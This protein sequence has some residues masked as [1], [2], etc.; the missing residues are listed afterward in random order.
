MTC[1]YPEGFRWLTSHPKPRVVKLKGDKF[2]RGSKSI[3]NRYRFY[4]IWLVRLEEEIIDKDFTQS[5]WLALQFLVQPNR[6]FTV[7]VPQACHGINN[8]S[9]T[10]T[11]KQKQHQNNKK[12]KNKNN[13]KQEHGLKNWDTCCIAHNVARKNPDVLF[14][15]A[16]H[17]ILKGS[18]WSLSFPNPLPT[19][20]K[21]LARKPYLNLNLSQLWQEKN[22]RIHQRR[23]GKRSS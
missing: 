9:K 6:I 3:K 22:S 7:G 16:R 23:E 18:L 17:V 10:I 1:Q 8:K 12:W 11:T 20:S 15:K 4:T 21:I 14:S 2:F 5:Y 13:K 19:G